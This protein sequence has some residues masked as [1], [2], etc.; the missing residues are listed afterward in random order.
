MDYYSSYKKIAVPRLSNPELLERINTL[1]TKSEISPNAF[2]FL[3]SL[4]AGFKKY[5]G[6]TQKQYDAFVDIEKSYLDSPVNHT[7]WM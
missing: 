3:S 2:S 4:A 7:E 5:G 1:R 6:V